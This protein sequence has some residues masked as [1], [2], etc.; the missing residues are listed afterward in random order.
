MSSTLT[1]CAVSLSIFQ[2]TSFQDTT[3]PTSLQADQARGLESFA[4]EYPVPAHT[5]QTMAKTVFIISTCMLILSLLGY[6]TIQYD[7]FPSD[8]GRSL[9][10]SVDETKGNLTESNSKE[11]PKRWYG[12]PPLPNGALDPNPHF[13]YPWPVICPG[14]QWIRYCFKDQRSMDMLMPVLREAILRWTPAFQHSSLR[15][16][17]D[18]GCNGVYE[19]LCSH[20]G[21]NGERVNVDSVVISVSLLKQS[22][23][24]ISL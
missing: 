17:P 8:P 7:P 9:A 10:E 13:A 23:A 2:T 18:L 20:V 3:L 14:K 15:I 1:V 5:V 6:A 11:I 16:Q 19:C 22:T 21:N 24:S 12:V 4:P